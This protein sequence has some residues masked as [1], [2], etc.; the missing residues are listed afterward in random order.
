[1][2]TPK[3]GK[4][5]SRAMKSQGRLTDWSK[6]KYVQDQQDKKIPRAGLEGCCS[7]QSELRAHV[8]F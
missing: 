7:I 6:M 5:P 4:N 2:E 3:S 8:S 1:M